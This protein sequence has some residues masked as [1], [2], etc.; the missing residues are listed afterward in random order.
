MPAACVGLA[1]Q[2]LSRRG[3]ESAVPPARKH[4]HF[5]AGS[6]NQQEALKIEQPG[7]GGGD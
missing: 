5:Q 7:L 4:D 2:G 6:S 1:G 3:G